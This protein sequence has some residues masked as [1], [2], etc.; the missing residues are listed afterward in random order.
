MNKCIWG[1]R[2]SPELLIAEVKAGMRDRFW[3]TDK[4]ME[5]GAFHRWQKPLSTHNQ[6]PTK[7]K[8]NRKAK[9]EIEFMEIAERCAWGDRL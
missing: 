3:N 5:E 9:I 7:T 2:E 4:E 1:G 8:Q 6:H